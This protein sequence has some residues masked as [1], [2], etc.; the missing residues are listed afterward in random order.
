MLFMYHFIV[1]NCQTFISAVFCAIER[2]VTPECGAD[3]EVFLILY[4]VSVT[5]LSK[6]LVILL[7]Y[8]VLVHRQLYMPR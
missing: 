8:S 6:H 3:G 7:E 2:S 1:K 4:N 5:C